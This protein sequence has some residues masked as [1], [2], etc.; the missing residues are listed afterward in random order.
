[1]H[2]LS[3]WQLLAQQSHL[4]LL[5][6]DPLWL[7]L[8]LLCT[9]Q[10]FTMLQSFTMPQQYTT[11]SMLQLSIMPQLFTMLQQYTTLSM[12]QFTMLLFIMLQPT[13]SPIM[14]TRS[15][16]ITVQLLTL[17]SLL[18]SVPQLSRLSVRTLRF[19]QR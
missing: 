6:V 5:Q 14:D 7:L 11:L 13:I 10:W 17:L 16:N 1:M 4:L 2:P 9:L 3:L 15:Q 12:H 19:H 18:K 8:L